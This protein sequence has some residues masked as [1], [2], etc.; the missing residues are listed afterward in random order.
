MT[1]SAS[2]NPGYR[3]PDESDEREHIV[4]ER[5]A[6]ELPN[7][8]RSAARALHVNTIAASEMIIVS[9]KADRR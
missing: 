2:R 9:E 5:I 4:E 1:I 6:V 7:R 8:F 3:E